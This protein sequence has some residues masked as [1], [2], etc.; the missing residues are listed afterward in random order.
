MQK[1]TSKC[2]SP[3]CTYSLYRPMR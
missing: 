2:S 1:S 3:T